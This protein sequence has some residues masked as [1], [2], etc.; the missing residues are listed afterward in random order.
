MAG[1]G[2]AV[3]GLTPLREALRRPLR[4]GSVIG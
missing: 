3:I 4:K 2:S 1:L